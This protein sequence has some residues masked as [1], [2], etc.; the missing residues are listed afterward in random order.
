MST[1]RPPL[2]PDEIGEIAEPEV[3]FESWEEERGGGARGGRAALSRRPF[4]PRPRPLPRPRPWPR[5][6][7]FGYPIPWWPEPTGGAP[8]QEPSTPPESEHVRWIQSSLNL[9]MG[10]RLPVD[11]VMGPETRSAIRSFQERAGLPADGIVGPDTERALIDAR[12]RRPAPSSE[13]ESFA[14]T[15]PLL[16]EVPRSSDRR[17]PSYIRWVQQRLNQ[18]MGAR[19][20]VDGRPG[21]ATRSAIRSFQQR[22]G[23]TADGVVGPRTEQALA[24]AGTSRPRVPPA[25]GP[26]LGTLATPASLDSTTSLLVRGVGLPTAPALIVRNFLDPRVP[27]LVGATRP[28]RSVTELIVHETETW[29]SA[30][31]VTVLQKRALG[32]HLIL[33][34]DG[35][36]T[37]HGDLGDDVTWHAGNHN[38]RS[39]GVEVVNPIFE[40]NLSLYTRLRPRGAPLPWSRTISAGWLE[41]GSYVLPTPTQAEAL[42]RLVAWITSPTARG[43]SIPRRWIGQADGSF[44]MRLVPGAERQT[45]GIYAHSHLSARKQD[46]P[47]LVLYA[48][49]RLEVGMTPNEAFEEAARLAAIPGISVVVPEPRATPGVPP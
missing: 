37:Q 17:S 18:V 3:D 6:L 26:A 38:G 7:P 14:A 46:G 1:W 23:L 48:W 25:P 42:V 5:P 31:T 40:R 34:P 29:S 4:R 21:P 41:G 47:W 15:E 16:D 12:A 9:V 2:D 19:L 30:D 32:V 44:A 36:L 11:G 27:R 35:A 39:V 49:L 33:G 28:G 22:H 13:L 45:A 10:F 24:G 43:L 20:A 8:V